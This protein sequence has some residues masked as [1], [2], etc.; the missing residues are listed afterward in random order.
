MSKVEKYWAHIDANTYQKITAAEVIERECKEPGKWRR[1]TYYSQHPPEQ[2][3]LMHHRR[4]HTGTCSFIYNPDQDEQI[5]RLGGGESLTH[6][7]FKMAISELGS[8]LLKVKGYIDAQINIKKS[9]IEK[10]FT[11]NGANYYVDVFCEFDSSG[12]LQL[13]WGGRL[14]IEVNHKHA[15]DTEKISNLNK[16]EIP[17]V[18]IDVS[19]KL[20]Y[21][22][23][24]EKSTPELEREYINFI[25]SK[26]SEYMWVTLL[27]NPCTKEYLE[28]KVLIL[29]SNISKIKNDLDAA[30]K[31]IFALSKECEMIKESRRS[32]NSRLD[33]QSKKVAKLESTIQKKNQELNNIKSKGI[34]KLI[35]SRIVWKYFPELEK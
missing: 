11:L 27:S 3:L 6:Y 19:D 16:M 9:S 18:E 32:L 17:V 23:S 2:R 12:D 24:E 29:E 22:H 28:K 4:S 34:F 31:Q 14:G 7:L 1:R 13:Q 30:N 5:S 10:Q 15:V 8:T 26:L 25:K 21:R 35:Y 20:I 33:E